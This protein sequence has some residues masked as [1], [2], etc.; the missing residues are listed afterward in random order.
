MDKYVLSDG[1]IK[2]GNFYHVPGHV[3]QKSF[4]TETQLSTTSQTAQITAYNTLFSVF[5][6]LGSEMAVNH[7]NILLGQIKLPRKF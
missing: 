2:H 5:C 4:E 3:V 7:T 6:G 1:L